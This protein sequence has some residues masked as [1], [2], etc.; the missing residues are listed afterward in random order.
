MKEC[1]ITE[2]ATGGEGDFPPCPTDHRQGR[3]NTGWV[4][5]SLSKGFAGVKGFGGVLTAECLAECLGGSQGKDGFQ[6]EPACTFS[7]KSSC[8]CKYK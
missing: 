4:S 7:F 2:T 5:E 6:A 8:I 1:V 3:G